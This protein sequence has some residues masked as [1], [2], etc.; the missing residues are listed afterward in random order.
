M[1]TVNAIV[2][3]QKAA[4][5]KAPS[6]DLPGDGMTDVERQAKQ[7][8]D[9]AKAGVD[10]PGADAG[11]FDNLSQKEASQLLFDKLKQLREL[12]RNN[13]EPRSGIAENNKKILMRRL[14]NNYIFEDVAA[15]KAIAELV[16]DIELLIPKVS[17][18]NARIANDALRKA[19]PYVRRHKAVVSAS[20]KS[21]ADKKTSR[22]NVPGNPLADFSKSGKGGLANDPDEQLAIDELQ[23]YLGIP[24]TGKY[25]QTTR[26]A[27]SAYQKRNKLKVKGNF[28]LFSIDFLSF[29]FVSL[30]FCFSFHPVRF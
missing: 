2:A 9:A 23:R 4:T 18:A 16:A 26:D 14:H 10:S 13:P 5:T 17:D 21:T 28:L 1:K 29:F 15:D 24:V 20:G 19:S 8:V 3:A 25:D 27:V 22:L 7:G 6:G 30:H 11:K 12:M